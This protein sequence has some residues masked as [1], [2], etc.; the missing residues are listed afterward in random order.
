VSICRGPYFTRHLEADFADQGSR[1]GRSQQVYLFVL[2][3]PSHDWKGKIATKFFPSIDQARRG[4]SAVTSLLHD[5]ITV[6]ARLTEV[7]VNGMDIVTLVLQP[8]ENDRSIETTRVSQY[9]TLIH[10]TIRSTEMRPVI[11]MSDRLNEI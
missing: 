9:A 3:L 8:A 1:D 2:G 11:E 10:E 4:S 6:F 5:R 7:D